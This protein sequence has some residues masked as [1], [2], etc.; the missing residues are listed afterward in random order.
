M[1]DFTSPPPNMEPVA[2]YRDGGGI[3]AEYARAAFDYK[4]KG[5][6]VKIV[7]ECYSACILALAVP[8]V[9]IGPKAVVK[10]HMAYDAK[11]G[12]VNVKVTE[13]MINVLPDKIGTVLWDNISVDYN[14]KT[15]FYASDLVKLGFKMCDT[16][17]EWKPT[18]VAADYHPYLKSKLKKR[19][20]DDRYNRPD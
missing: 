7:G 5:R 20:D 2:I 14:E 19:R 6:K 12:K 11:T 18:T 13:A 10:A 1:S 17:P 15:I 16:V 3:V 4:A 9:C 8:D